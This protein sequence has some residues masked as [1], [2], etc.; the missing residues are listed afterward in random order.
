MSV[1]YL[2]SVCDEHPYAEYKEMRKYLEN[3]LGWR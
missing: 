3:S 1:E 2:I